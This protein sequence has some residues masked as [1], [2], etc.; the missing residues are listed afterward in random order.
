MPRTPESD[1]TDGLSPREC[2]VASLV[3]LGC[4]NLEIA[5][6]LAISARTVETHVRSIFNRLGFHRRTE[7]A[8]WAVRAGLVGL[9]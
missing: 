3:A 8:V 9:R 6:Q 1:G 4:T 7:V 5:V 2:E